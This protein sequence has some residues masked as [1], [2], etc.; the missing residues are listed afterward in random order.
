MG[1][2]RNKRWKKKRR[3]G[4]LVEMI[5]KKSP[6]SHVWYLEWKLKDGREGSIWDDNGSFEVAFADKL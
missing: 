4:W 2:E 1:E 6:F 3:C 5:W